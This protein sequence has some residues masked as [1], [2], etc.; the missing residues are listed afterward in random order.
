MYERSDEFKQAIFP[1]LCSSQSE[2]SST[3][4]SKSTSTTTT[5]RKRQ[6]QGKHLAKVDAITGSSRKRPKQ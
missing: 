3:T 2:S 4:F 5:Q 1:E 6:L